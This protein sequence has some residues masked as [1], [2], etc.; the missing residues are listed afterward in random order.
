MVRLLSLIVP[1]GMEITT[2]HRLYEV[3]EG[4]DLTFI[5]GDEFVDDRTAAIMGIGQ[6]TMDGR[7]EKPM[8]SRLSFVL[9]EAFQNIIRHRAQEGGRSMLMVQRG[10]AGC[11]V[12]AV[13]P[14]TVE[15][16][17]A[18]RQRMESIHGLDLAQLKALFLQR[19]QGSSTSARGGAGLGLIEMARRSGRTPQYQLWPGDDGRQLFALHVRLGEEAPEVDLDAM[20]WLHGTVSGL[21][22]RMLT[23]GLGGPGLQQA[24]LDLTALVAA[25]GR[26]VRAQRIF[27][28]VLEFIRAHE[29]CGPLMMWTSGPDGH[30]L[31]I[32]LRLAPAEAE[33]LHAQV[34][35]VR[36]MDAQTLKQHYRDRLL[37]RKAAVEVD[38]GLL[39]LVRHARETVRLDQAARGDRVISL[40]RVPL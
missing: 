6:E 19:L 3:L 21:N 14:V 22:I 29:T 36:D 23:Q 32:G 20:R 11:V 28:A 34:A 15:E 27:L 4:R 25:A 7:A 5:Y 31:Y 26:S 17:R 8:R 33:R 35:R 10:G 37:G 16:G 38:L 18:L 24:L 30:L 40:L 39:D 13:N 2:V 9:V 1:Y 12:S